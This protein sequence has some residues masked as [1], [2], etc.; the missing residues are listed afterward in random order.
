MKWTLRC[1]DNGYYY[2]REDSV[3][4]RFR[5]ALYALMLIDALSEECYAHY[6]VIIVSLLDAIKTNQSTMVEGE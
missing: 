4:Y 1:D 3:R 5:D 6:H 2:E